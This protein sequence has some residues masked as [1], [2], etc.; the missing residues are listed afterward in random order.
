MEGFVLYALEHKN[1]L[2]SLWKALEEIQEDLDYINRRI[3]ADE[4]DFHLLDAI[5][6]TMRLSFM[7]QNEK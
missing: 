3:E 7:G 1:K 6:E 5:D 4:K 2:K